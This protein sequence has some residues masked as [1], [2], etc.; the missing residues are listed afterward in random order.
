[1][2]E[3]SERFYD[4]T[5]TVHKFFEPTETLENKKNHVIIFLKKN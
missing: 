4:Y 2:S 1:M 3:V 5:A